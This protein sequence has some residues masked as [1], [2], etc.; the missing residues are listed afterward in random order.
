MQMLPIRV[1]GWPHVSFYANS[2]AISGIYLG[3]GEGVLRHWWD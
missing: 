1:K 2:K 3:A